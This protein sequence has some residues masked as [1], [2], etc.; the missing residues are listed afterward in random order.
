[1][2]SSEVADQKSSP[3][4]E[5]K[6]D[7]YEKN[8]EEDPKDEDNFDDETKERSLTEADKPRG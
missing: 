1:M 5:I 2:D 4:E 8:L 7:A 3:R 6:D